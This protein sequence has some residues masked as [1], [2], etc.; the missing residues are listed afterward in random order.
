MG[1]TYYFEVFAD[2]FKVELHDEGA[3]AQSDPWDEASL[4]DWVSVDKG[5]IRI[6]TARNMKVPVIVNISDNNSA[7]DQEDNKA[8]A[9]WD[10]VI[11]CSIDITSGYLVLWGNDYYP[12]A[13]RIALN[14]DTYQIQI[15]YG[16]LNTL[17]EDGLD[18]NDVY[19]IKIRP[20]PPIPPMVKKRALA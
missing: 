7:V 13:P 17:S 12:D 3:E 1:R 5:V 16:G 11:E 2:Y 8:F 15:Y 14:P 9:S 10:H 19:L 6:R 18:G 20:G 4:N